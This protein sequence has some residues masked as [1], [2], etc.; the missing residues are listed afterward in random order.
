MRIVA[1]PEGGPSSGEKLEISLVLDH[2]AWRIAAIHSN[3][4]VGP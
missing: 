4:P 2:G 1:V 3:V